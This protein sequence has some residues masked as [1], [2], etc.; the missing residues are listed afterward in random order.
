MSAKTAQI[1]SLDTTREREKSKND[2]PILA[3]KINSLC[4]PILTLEPM[5]PLKTTYL[6]F[7]LPMPIASS[8]SS[9]HF[10]MTFL[11]SLGCL[12]LK[13]SMSAKYGSTARI[14]THVK[15]QLTKTQAKKKDKK[16]T[17]K[18]KKAGR[19]RAK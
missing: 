1:K 16:D 10:H 8:K 7:T 3:Q 9:N 2:L 5:P 13:C 4:K 14:K 12:L 19:E 15:T 6:S 18:W 17:V 11:V